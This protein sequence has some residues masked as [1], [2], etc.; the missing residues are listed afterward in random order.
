[1]EIVWGHI[2]EGLRTLT[3]LE[4][5]FVCTK[6]P[7]KSEQ[8]TNLVVCVF[9]TNYS[10]GAVWKGVGPF[11]AMESLRHVRGFERYSYAACRR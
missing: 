3:G 2:L 6:E 7:L 5:D 1:M 4:L 11:S 10:S 8:K 9:N